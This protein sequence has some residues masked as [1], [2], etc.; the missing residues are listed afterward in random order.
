MMGACGIHGEIMHSKY[1]LRNVNGRIHFGY[2]VFGV[3]GLIA[4]ME[5]CF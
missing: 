5:C 2:S 4:G 1:W 3:A